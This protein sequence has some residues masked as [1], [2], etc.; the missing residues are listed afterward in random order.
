LEVGLDDESAVVDEAVL[1]DD[2]EDL[3]VDVDES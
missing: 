1:V 3:A 2:A